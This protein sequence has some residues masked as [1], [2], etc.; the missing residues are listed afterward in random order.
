MY[1][2]VVR[3][4][5]YTFPKSEGFGPVVR[6]DAQ[7]LILGSLPGK[8]SL[9]R[10]EYYAHP[11]NA[12]WTIMGILFGAP[13]RMPYA[14]RLQRLQERRIALWDVCASAR[15]P[16]SLDSELSDE[17]PNDFDAF[18]GQH[19]DIVL[20]GFNGAKAGRIFHRRVLPGLAPRFAGIRRVVLPSTSPAHAAMSLEEKVERWREALDSVIKANTTKQE[21]GTCQA[22][23]PCQ[24]SLHSMAP[25][26]KDA[27]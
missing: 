19:E 18:L 12:F 1:R 10:G 25:N 24:V 20:I 8:V 6:R 22:V 2:E 17:L 3:L 21:P 4:E 11:R 14:T 7:V 15:R 27:P 23:T 26:A 9:E 13:R 5:S 16:G